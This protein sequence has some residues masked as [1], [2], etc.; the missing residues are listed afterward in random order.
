MKIMMT[1]WKWLAIALLAITVGACKP[2][3]TTY[4]NGA[5]GHLFIIG[6]GNRS[7]ALMERFVSLAGGAQSKVVVVPFASSVPEE[8]GAAQADELSALGC[9]ASYVFFE[10]GDADLEENLKKLDGVTGIFFSGGD[11]VRLAD[12]LLGT[13]FLDKIKDIYY[14]GGVVGGTSAGAAVM[15]KIM[16]TGNELVSGDTTLSFA[17]IK[18]GNVEVSEGFGLIDFAIIDQHFIQRKREN[19][20]I[21]LVI[22]NNLPG[23]GIDEAT[24]I[25]VGDG[26]SFEVFGDRTVM[27]FEPQLSQPSRTDAKSNLSADHIKLSILLSGDR[28]DLQ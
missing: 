9:E 12:V 14:Q 11:Q 21:N 19:R 2:A 13:K 8:T 20:L 22:E 27:V 25:I 28:Y 23:I 7:E 5:K 26:H 3:V 18:K 1:R 17:S 16:I 10:K 4:S 15:S 24:A 6:G